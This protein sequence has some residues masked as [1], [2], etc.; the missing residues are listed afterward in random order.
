VGG[1]RSRGWRS[2]YVCDPGLSACIS[3]SATDKKSAFAL[4]AKRASRAT[5]A[6]SG[7]AYVTREDMSDDALTILQRALTGGADHVVFV[8]PH[9]RFAM[10]GA[11]IAMSRLSRATVVHVTSGE[12]EHE[13]REALELAGVQSAV[14]LQAADQDVMQN[15]AT[16]TAQLCDVLD[17]LQPDVVVTCSYGGVHP[18]QD[19]TAV[20]VSVASRVP[21]AEMTAYLAPED[22]DSLVSP[23]ESPLLHME[24]SPYERQLKRSIVGCFEEQRAMLEEFPIAAERFRNAPAYHFA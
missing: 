6:G 10:A 13:A 16:V 24:L 17:R 2:V 1:E 12:R 9:P 11:G 8:A 20:A 18:V 23:T 22:E 15:L 19:G 5:P 14:W 3:S 7:I 4:R 21:V